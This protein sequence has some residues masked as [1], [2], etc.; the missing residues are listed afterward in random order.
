MKAKSH[1]TWP[2]HSLNFMPYLSVMFVLFMLFLSY[3]S[4]SQ[5]FTD[6]DK[7]KS[8]YYDEPHFGFSLA[9]TSMSNPDA[10]YHEVHRQSGFT[11]QIYYKKYN[12]DKGDTRMYWQNKSIGDLLNLLVREIQTDKGAE[13][14][15][16]SVLSDLIGKTSW[17]WNVNN[18]RRLS[19]AVGFNLND[20]I[21]GATYAERFNGEPVNLKT[22]E[23]QG[24]YWA[25][26]PSVFVDYVLT[27][28]LVLQAFAS[29]SLS[30]FRAVSVSN[31]VKDKSYPKPHFANINIE[32]Q[33]SLRLY[34]GID[35][36]WLINR[37]ALPNK[38]RRLDVVVG[39]RF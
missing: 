37:G 39:F 14:E 5:S 13:R 27:N 4:F 22:S 19:T 1:S 26:G 9:Y 2:K 36:T 32:L 28:D 7:Q 16:G 17:G 8:A 23:P 29:Y 34:G 6:F 18:A 35:Y 33:T 38:T 31:A 15:E 24:Y 20:Y 11:M 10:P 21:I 3:R 25:T 12:L 30:M